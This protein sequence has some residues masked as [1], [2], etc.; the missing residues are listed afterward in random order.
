MMDGEYRDG[1]VNCW[2][3]VDSFDSVFNGFYFNYH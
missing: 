1:V 3:A 2:I